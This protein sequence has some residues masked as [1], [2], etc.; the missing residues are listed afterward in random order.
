MTDS[1]CRSIGSMATLR[2]LDQLA[3]LLEADIILLD[4]LRHVAL[5]TQS[6]E[7]RS[8]IHFLIRQVQQG[9]SLATGFRSSPFHHP[10]AL[11]A[12]IE[13]GERS[14][15]LAQ[16]L[17]HM[18]NDLRQ[19][20]ELSQQLIQ[21]LTYPVVILCVALL[22][23]VALLVWVVPQ[24][25]SMFSSFGA[26]LP[27]ATQWV[28]QTADQLRAHGVL[29]ITSIVAVFGIGRWHA[30]RQSQLWHQFQHASSKLPLIGM[31]LNQRLYS[32]TARLLSTLLDAG[33]PLTTTLELGACASTHARHRAALKASHKMIENGAPLSK[34]LAETHAFDPTL[35]QLIAVGEQSGQLAR[36]L[37]QAA[38]MAEQSVNMGVKQFSSLV[39]PF[40]MLAIGLLMGGLLIALYL[41]IFSMSTIMM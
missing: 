9:H 3:T 5:T 23:T 18:V 13:A 30:K 7:A 24:F 15:T 37:G 27:R 20:L 2:W 1:R 32:N 36:M 34:A 4:A 33:L 28:I 35:I 22:V 6:N 16:V 17:R 38:N 26:P 41:P 10:A 40:M 31:L 8:L 39:E 11:P 25:E 19:R 14:G 21:A 12:L 29:L